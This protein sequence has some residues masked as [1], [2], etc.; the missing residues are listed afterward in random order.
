MQLQKTHTH[1]R[2][3]HAAKFRKRLQK[4]DNTCGEI[5]HNT[6]GVNQGDAKKWRLWQ[7]LVVVA[8]PTVLFFEATSTEGQASPSTFFSA[9][10]LQIARVIE[11]EQS[12]KE[13]ESKGPRVGLKPLLFQLSVAPPCYVLYQVTPTH[14]S[15][16]QQD[17][18]VLF[19]HT[20]CNAMKGNTVMNCI[21]N[22]WAK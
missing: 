6:L 16:I 18:M 19:T 22:D 11:R 7:G 10:V 21:R 1:K 4:L 9:L 3:K 15:L 2:A 12:K 13:R 14:V 8:C 17:N 20:S 5:I